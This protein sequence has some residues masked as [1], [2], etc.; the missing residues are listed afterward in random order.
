LALAA[1]AWIGYVAN[2][3]G[4]IS[5]PEIRSATTVQAGGDFES[6]DYDD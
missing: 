1:A 4:Q 3:G 6:G 5:H 2:L